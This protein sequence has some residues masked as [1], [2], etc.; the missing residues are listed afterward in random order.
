MKIPK[1]T[2]L[3]SLTAAQHHWARTLEL[4]R[5]LNLTLLG[6]PSKLD[7]ILDGNSPPNR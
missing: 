1:E 7:Y 2:E 5:E 6:K 3:E 4:Q